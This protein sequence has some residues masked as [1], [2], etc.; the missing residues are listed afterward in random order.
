MAFGYLLR[1]LLLLSLD[2]R[3]ADA[4]DL[5]VDVL[6]RQLVLNELSLQPSL[7]AAL[8]SFTRDVRLVKLSQ[9]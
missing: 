3:L 2:L 6:L 7:L 9:I 4:L 5:F 8:G 1:H